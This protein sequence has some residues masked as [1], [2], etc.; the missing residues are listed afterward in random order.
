MNISTYDIT[1][2]DKNSLSIV[3]RQYSMLGK[4][5]FIRQD[6]EQEC[7]SKKQEPEEKERKTRQR[8]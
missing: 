2:V 3:F 4:R 1:T 6:L 8:M 7:L 5:A